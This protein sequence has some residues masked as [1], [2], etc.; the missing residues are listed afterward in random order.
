MC[1]FKFQ[2][3]NKWALEVCRNVIRTGREVTL[4]FGIGME[5]GIFSLG[6]NYFA[7]ISSVTVDL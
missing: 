7:I 2:G 3:W 4:S 6:S 1:M 5:G